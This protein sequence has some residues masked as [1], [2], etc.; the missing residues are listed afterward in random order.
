MTAKKLTP[1]G[2]Q[3]VVRPRVRPPV[4]VTH[5]RIEEEEPTMSDHQ[6]ATPMHDA[7][8]IDAQTVE[9]NP[10]TA[11]TLAEFRKIKCDMTISKHVSAALGFGFIP[12]P[13]VDFVGI[14]GVQLDM[15]YRL[16]RIYDVDFST[17][18]ARSVIAAL[19]GTGLPMQPLLASSL[20]MIPGIGTAAGIFAVPALAGASTYALGRVFVQHFETG[21]TL[22]TFDAS[23]MKAHFEHA[24]SEGKNVV[25]GMRGSK[26]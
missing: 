7:D 19:I 1:R 2:S 4:A 17:Q 13:L 23:K 15:L 18:A 24:M 10:P 26:S 5:A 12:L 21:G 6:T 9:T 3:R 11:A 22:L 8:T 25:S 20:K 14:S 16:C